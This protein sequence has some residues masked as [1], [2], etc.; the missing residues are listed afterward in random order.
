MQTAHS[1]T[2]TTPAS[3]SDE[4]LLQHF[5]KRAEERKTSVEIMRAIV[6]VAKRSY[7]QAEFIWVGPT[8]EQATAVWREVT[9][10]GFYKEADFCWGGHGTRWAQALEIQH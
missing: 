4:V 10:D 5:L 9:H 7:I 6:N 2:I 1:H 3:S 8:P